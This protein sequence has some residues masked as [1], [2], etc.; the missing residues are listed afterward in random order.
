MKYIKYPKTFHF[1]YSENISNDD[2][3]LKDDNAFK[4][5]KCIVGSIKMDG[6]NTSVYSNGY[7]HARSIDGNHHS[8][9]DWLKGYIQN[10]FYKI[11]NGWRICGENLYAKHTI[12][13]EFD[14][15]YDYFQIF[16]IYDENNNCL[17]WL[18]VLEFCEENN[19]KT[20]PIFYLGQYD[21]DKI[22]NKF[23]EFKKFKNGMGQE[24]EGFVIRNLDG[25]S[26]DEFQNNVG[27]FVRKNHVQTDQH[28]KQN[29]VMN[30]IKGN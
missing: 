5:M 26:Y 30:K 19:L 25:F 18:D 13:Y 15:Q 1:E 10:W 3:V 17:P 11:P 14:S 16:G 21:K 20:V 2:K 12:A 8:S 7:I 4:N 22:L 27:K 29:W 6:E 24:V 9:Q 28:W 23:N